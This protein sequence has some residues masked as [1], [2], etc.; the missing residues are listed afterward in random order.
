[1]GGKKGNKKRKTTSTNIC[2]PVLTPSSQKRMYRYCCW[3]PILPHLLWEKE[4]N[5]KHFQSTK[6]HQSP[7][8]RVEDTNGVMVGTEQEG[9]HVGEQE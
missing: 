5:R 3:S 9:G 7:L 8:G 6:Q 4:T 2:P 1:M